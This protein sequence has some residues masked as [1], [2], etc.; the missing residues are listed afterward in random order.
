VAQQIEFVSEIYYHCKVAGGGVNLSM[1]DLKK[2]LGQMQ[3]YRQ[4]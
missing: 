1:E 3:N 4:V 2:V